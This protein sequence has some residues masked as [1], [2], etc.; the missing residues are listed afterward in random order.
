M[1]S[2]SYLTTKTTSDLCV[3]ESEL[4]SYVENRTESQ[5][6]GIKHVLCFLIETANRKLKLELG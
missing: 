5:M 3:V 4:D 1:E 2:I 6:K